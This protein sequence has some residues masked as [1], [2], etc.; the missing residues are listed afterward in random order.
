VGLQPVLPRHDLFTKEIRTL[1]R[2]GKSLGKPSGCGRSKI[3]NQNSKIAE[4][5]AGL[6]HRLTPGTFQSLERNESAG[7]LDLLRVQG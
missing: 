3:K 4:P 1:L 7:P 5:L 6:F 2:G